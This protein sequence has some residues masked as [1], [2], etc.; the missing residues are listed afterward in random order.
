MAI[1]PKYGH[2]GILPYGHMAWDMDNIGVYQESN[3]N[4]AIWSRRLI[5]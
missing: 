1:M 3:G 4:V 5:D 2:N